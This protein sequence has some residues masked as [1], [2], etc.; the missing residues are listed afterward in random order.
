[1]K[2]PTCPDTALVMADRQGVEI[3]YCPQCRGVWLDRGE[4]DK[5]IERSGRCRRPAASASA[6]HSRNSR[7]P[8]TSTAKARNVPRG[9]RG[10][11]RREG[12]ATRVARRT[13]GVRFREP[14]SGT[15][16]DEATTGIGFRDGRRRR[17][18]PASR[19]PRTLANRRCRSAGYRIVDFVLVE[20]GQLGIYS[21]YLLVQYKSQSLIEHVRRPGRLADPH[22]RVRH[23][24]AAADARGGEWYQGTADAVYQNLHLIET[25]TARTSWRSSAP[26]TST[27]WTCGRW[28]TSTCDAGP[29]S[30]RGAAGA[31]RRGVV[32][33]HHR[34]RRVPG[35]SSSSRRSR[36]NPTPMPGGPRHACLDGQLPVQR[37]ACWSTR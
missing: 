36:R 2:C 9:S 26:T 23:G 28:S 19:S 16:C 31:A 1:M 33:R 14:G 25:C 17:H 30:G 34:R 20:P 6:H 3:D 15:R 29:T 24:G 7:T 13:R 27:G 4:L 35:A 21:I 8:T 11:P 37:R 12:V 22:G 10:E 5:L 18:A 32:V